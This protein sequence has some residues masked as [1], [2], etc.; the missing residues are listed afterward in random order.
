MFRRQ[1]SP[2]PREDAAFDDAWTELLDR[3]LAFA[4]VLSGSPGN[5]PAHVNEAYARIRDRD[6]KGKDLRGE[7]LYAEGCSAI[8]SIIGDSRRAAHLKHE[9]SA[10]MFRRPEHQGE[11]APD[12]A[13]PSVDSPAAVPDPETVLDMKQDAETLHDKA[14]RAIGDDPLALAVLALALEDVFEPKD[15]AARLGRTVD[16]INNAQE[17]IRRR[18]ERLVTRPE[19]KR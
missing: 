10:V 17:R 8:R 19:K 5:V 16:E 11:N 15:L 18:C 9:K 3:F 2:P 1:R 14:K 7:A 4:L 13:P 12:D 6:R